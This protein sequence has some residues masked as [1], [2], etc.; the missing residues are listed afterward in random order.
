MSALHVDFTKDDHPSVQEN[1]RAS[2]STKAITG[3]KAVG[4]YILGSVASLC[5]TII[6]L[7]VIVITDLT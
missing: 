3:L 2:T 7:V 1:E 6:V 5:S 4:S